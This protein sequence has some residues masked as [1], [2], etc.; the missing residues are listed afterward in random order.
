LRILRI[1]DTIG[2]NVP[3]GPPK[4]AY[5]LTEG[6]ARKGISS[7]VYTNNCAE[8]FNSSLVEVKTFKP[9]SKMGHYRLNPDMLRDLLREDADIVHVHG[10]RNFESDAGAF[11]AY[12]TG[13]PC[14][15]TCHGTVLGPLNL[16]WSMQ[17]RL[18]DLVYD[19]VTSKFTLRHSDAL[20]ATTIKEAEEVASLGVKKSKIVIVPNAVDLASVPVIKRKDDGLVRV[21][22]VSRLTFKNNIEMAIRGFAKAIQSNANLRLKIVGDE[23]PSR[24]VGQE[25]GYKE[26]LRTLCREL[27]LPEDKVEFT[28]WLNGQDLWNA[29]LNSDIFL[30][31]SRYDNFAHALVEAANFS[32]PIVSTDV[33]IASVIIGSKGEGGILVP[34]ED[35]NAV[36]RAL[37]EISGDS[38]LRKKMGE[39]NKV[40]SA[41]FTVENMVT[42]YIRV[43]E[44]LLRSQ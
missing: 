33:G 27:N 41:E 38:N 36:A 3:S 28:G 23:S 12:L 9:R 21:L 39:Q 1:I 17:S 25:R 14:V 34:Q 40:K 32:L 31:T 29:Y 22:L 20:V 30:W 7:I 24:F 10:Y 6:L 19:G 37:I 8:Q 15:M 35:V 4:M 18:Q 42:R 44:N 11:S 13:K 16:T 2:S 26:K 43:Y 5:E